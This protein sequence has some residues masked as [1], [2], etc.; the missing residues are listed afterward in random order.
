MIS[1]GNC[2]HASM[3]RRACKQ[4][5]KLVDNIIAGWVVPRSGH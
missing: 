2:P 3:R 1:L 4:D 5:G